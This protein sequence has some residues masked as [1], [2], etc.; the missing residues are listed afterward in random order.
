MAKFHASCA[1]ARECNGCA[2]NFAL[3]VIKQV[4]TKELPSAIRIIELIALM[5]PAYVANMAPPF[6]RFWH[7]PNPPI[8]RK[9][10]G[11]HK[12]IGG[13]IVATLVGVV[14][15]W[16]LSNASFAGLPQWDALPFSQHWFWFGSS[17][18]FAAIAGDSLKSFFKR[19][20]NIQ[21]GSPWIPFD[22]I[23]FVLAALIVMRFWIPV[24]WVEAVIVA[25]LSFLGDVLINQ[26]SYRIG[27]K[28][29]P[30]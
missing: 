28:R 19:R 26:I 2:T 9:W 8:S 14:T 25:V 12:T 5:A 23:D 21:P 15:A 18:G 6:L 22:Q 30:W 17:M 20:L 10:L 3:Y 13:F 1:W 29:D 16:G 7:G 4:D 24:S 11:D 27:I